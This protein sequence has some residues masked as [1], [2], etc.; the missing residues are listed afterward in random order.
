MHAQVEIREGETTVHNF[1]EEGGATVQGLCTPPPTGGIIGFAVLR[2]PGSASALTGL[3]LTNP[4][5]WFGG[6]EAGGA[7]TVLGMSPIRDDG[8]FEIENCPEGNYQLDIL[9]VNL[10]EAM[11]GTGKPRTSQTVSISGEETI[12]LNISV[13]GS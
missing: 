1:G 3:N 7:P 12:E 13:P 8:Y 2:V 5:D 4:A 11:S 6:T 9:Y 10:G